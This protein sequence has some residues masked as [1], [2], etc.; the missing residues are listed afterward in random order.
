MSDIS[1][2]KHEQA[3]EWVDQLLADK[4]KSAAF[5]D[6]HQTWSNAPEVVSE[7]ADV[8][9]TEGTCYASGRQLL[10]AALDNAVTDFEKL[11]GAKP[12]GAV[13]D[14]AVRTTL[15]SLSREHRLKAG[16][17]IAAYDDIEGGTSGAPMQ[18]NRAAISV[19][20]TIVEAL[21]FGGLIPMGSG[22]QGKIIIATHEA[23]NA[24]GDYAINDSLDGIYAG[25][26]FMNAVRRVVATSSD[27]QAYTAKILYAKGDSN[28]SPIVASSVRV[29]VNGKPAGGTL[30]TQTNNKTEAP[31]NGQI[32]VN[33]QTHTLTGKAV[34]ATGEVT[35]NV[36][37]ALQSSDVVK[38]AGM[39]NFEDEKMK[40]KRPAFQ[41]SAYSYD[42]RATFSS[43]LYRIT[44]EAKA[45]FSS[46]TNLDPASEAMLAMR[47]QF[48]F[49]RHRYALDC[50]YDIAQG[51]KHTADMKT[52][53]RLDERSRVQ[54]W[55]DVLFA[56]TEADQSMLE[57][58][59]AFGIGVLY[60]GGKGRAELEALPPEL[61]EK[62][63]VP[64]RAGIYRVGQ[65]FGRYE[66]Y[67]CPQ[68]LK[69]TAS[70]IEILA[71]G[72]SEQSGLNPIVV[73]DVVAPTFVNLGV[74]HDLREGAA[75][76]HAGVLEVNPHVSAASGAALIAITGL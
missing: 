48:N 23:G 42:L 51:Y 40:G 50:M 37:P 15:N 53:T 34:L 30:V 12:S 27:Q 31:I 55:S 65:L 57:R 73:G 75:Y 29:F 69:E 5:D 26:P 62:S 4:T 9:R 13:L 1:Y 74:T 36:T 58:T 6:T 54:L 18:A 67:Y 45:Q 66:V 76:F 19:Y 60:V 21:P 28:G 46:E 2:P 43:G 49:E 63:T 17:D 59:N 3:K 33:N 32:V 38:V 72:R 64:A 8:I 11:H 70:S 61:F 71:I 10:A 68:L 20:N 39:I 35:I 22:L 14:N 47:N 52:S 24:V 56:L 16:V 41:T 44:Q 25:K 7:L